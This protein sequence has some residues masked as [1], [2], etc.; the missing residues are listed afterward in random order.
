[1]WPDYRW[2]TTSKA[3]T[4]VERERNPNT[5]PERAQGVAQVGG[6]NSGFVFQG[7]V[8]FHVPSQQAVERGNLREL[9]KLLL[10][11]FNF[12]PPSPDHQ[13]L[14]WVFPH[15]VSVYVQDGAQ[16]PHPA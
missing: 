16:L 11:P 2:T 10:K 15:L 12:I 13:V 6:L 9:P 7:L 8:L 3:R 1:M 5:G 14:N 4:D